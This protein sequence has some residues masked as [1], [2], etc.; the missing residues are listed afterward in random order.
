MNIEQIQE[1]VEAF[2][3]GASMSKKA[4]F[5]VIEIHC[6]HGYLLNEFLSPLQ[7]NVLI[8][9]VGVMKIAI[10]FRRSD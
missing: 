8:C 4:G 1:V 6:A 3:L 2:R 5:D 10:T 9:M 7:I